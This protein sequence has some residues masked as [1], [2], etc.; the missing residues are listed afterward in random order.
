MKVNMSKKVAVPANLKK[1]SKVGIIAA[2]VVV[3]A[4][5]GFWAVRHFSGPMSVDSAISHVSNEAVTGADLRMAVVRMDAIQTE[6][7]VL[8]D[9]RKQRESYETKLR[10]ELTRRQKELEKEKVEIEKSQDVLSREALQKRVVEYQQKVSK[11]QQDLTTRAQAIETSFQKALN[12]IQ[13]DHL[14]PIVDAI[15]AKKN[16][17]LVI[18]GRFARVAPSAIKGLDITPD[19]VAALDK[20]I[21]NTKMETPKGF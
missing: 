3:V 1:Y 2:A 6:A 9:L 16:L 7:K 19:I 17:S 11:L 10:D 15:I 5:L 14:D 21:S 20:R 8:I 12:K 18:D 4:I 13:S